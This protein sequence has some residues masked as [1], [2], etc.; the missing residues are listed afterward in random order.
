MLM[1][2]F[3]VKRWSIYWT[4]ST[5][6]LTPSLIP[7]TSIRYVQP[8]SISTLW[9]NKKQATIILPITSP[10]VDDFQNSFTDRFISKFATKRLL[11]IPPHLNCVTTLPCEISEFKK[12]H[13]KR[14]LII[15]PHLNC[16]TTLPCEI[17]EFKKC[18]TQDLSLWSKLSCKTQP[19]RTVVKIPD[20]HF[21]I[22]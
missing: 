5:Q 4:T 1:F 6:R 8:V 7:W 21:S 13:T 16:V 15:L 18:H 3:C 12:C 10:N 20:S 11:I 17:S 9:V 14:L 2:V 22:I 19:L